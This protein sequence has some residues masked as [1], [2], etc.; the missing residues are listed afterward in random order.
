MEHFKTTLV[1]WGYAFLMGSILGLIV[2]QTI[3]HNAIQKDCEIL[4]AFRIGNI[5]YSCKVIRP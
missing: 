5:A 2:E 4:G 3:M 1:R